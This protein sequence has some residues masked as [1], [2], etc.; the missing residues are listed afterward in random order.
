MISY[1]RKIEL[2][3]CDNISE[4]IEQS[5]AGTKRGAKIALSYGT[6]YKQLFPILMPELKRID[7]LLFPADERIVPIQHADSN[8]G[9]I[10]RNYITPMKL[11]T[12]FVEG[13]T[14]IDQYK[15]VF[16][17]HFHTS[18]PIFD[19]I[20]LGL[21]A[22]GHIASLFPAVSYPDWPAIIET[23][24]PHHPHKRLSLSPGVLKLT[25]R[26]IL[27]VI[28]PA[29]KKVLKSI[30]EG[31]LNSPLVSIISNRTKTDIITTKEF[32]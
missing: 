2:S 8:W 26:L 29:K 9:E 1:S 24:S 6:T 19:I 23:S 11:R 28:D 30:I 5:V 21:G 25:E 10:S 4:I 22:D 27:I 16:Q 18:Q 17:E 14:S 32:I 31:N 12:P 20:F 7:A 3:H 13:A 15:T